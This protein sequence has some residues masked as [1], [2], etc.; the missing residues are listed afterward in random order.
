MR[1]LRSLRP[2][3]RLRDYEATVDMRQGHLR[4]AAVPNNRDNLFAALFRA[5][6]ADRKGSSLRKLPF[7]RKDAIDKLRSMSA[8]FLTRAP[9]AHLRTFFQTEG[10][11]QEY[12]QSINSGQGRGG[13]PDLIAIA[14]KFHITIIL[15]QTARRCLRFTRTHPDSDRPEVHIGMETSTRFHALV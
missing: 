15:H 8:A 3:A 4:K 7:D 12:A 2:P 5:W 14:S 13:E 10:E 11:K 9:L 6:P 1:P